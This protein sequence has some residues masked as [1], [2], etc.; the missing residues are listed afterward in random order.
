MC[1]HIGNA[2]IIHKQVVLLVILILLLYKINMI[3]NIQI[4]IY[5]Y[6][7]RHVCAYIDKDEHKYWIGLGLFAFLH[8]SLQTLGCGVM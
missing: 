6:M 4:N 2:S 7:S 5:I 1:A 8:A 3:T